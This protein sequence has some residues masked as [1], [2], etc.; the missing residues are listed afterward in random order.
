MEFQLDLNAGELALVQLSVRMLKYHD[1]LLQQVKVLHRQDL[2]FTTKTQDLTYVQGM[3][4]H[5]V[6]KRKN[7]KNGEV[8]AFHCG[9]KAFA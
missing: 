7:R 5:S 3:C 4:A 9:S 6:E 1:Q 8:Q 2:L